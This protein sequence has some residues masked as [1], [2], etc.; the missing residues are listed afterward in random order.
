MNAQRTESMT[1]LVKLA[2]VVGY[3]LHAHVPRQALKS[4]CRDDNVRIGKCLRLLAKKG[5]V[6]A[7]P[8]HGETTWQLT[9]PGLTLALEKA[10]VT[11][12]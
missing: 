9:R 6:V 1:I 7:H 4:R 11:S 5:L 10:Q 2:R 12:T 3:S 8:T